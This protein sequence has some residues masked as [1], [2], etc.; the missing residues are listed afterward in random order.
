MK[1][2]NFSEL[3]DVVNALFWGTAI[4]IL[5]LVPIFSILFI[6][7]LIDAI[8]SK[9]KEKKMTE[10][11]YQRPNSYQIQYQDTFD[12]VPKNSVE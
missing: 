8:I 7:S 5:L 6:A 2:E 9:S 10:E 4:F 3:L 12:Y 1:L 11:I